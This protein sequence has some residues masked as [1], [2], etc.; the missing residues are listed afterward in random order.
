MIKEIFRYLLLAIVLLLLQL[1][2][3]N[4]INFHGFVNPYVYVMFVLVMPFSLKKWQLLVVG[5]VLGLVV[6]M[7]MNTLGLHAAATLMVAF[8]RPSI[9]FRFTTRV[10]ES[11]FDAPGIDAGLIWFLRYV[12]IA[13]LVHHSVLFFLE[14][15]TLRH[16]AI[17]LLRI[18]LSTAFTTVFILIIEAIRE[19][20]REVK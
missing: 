14:V 4:N 8:L 20:R 11:R 18:V 6:D 13:V 16:F 19:L 7:F 17:T 9:L 2:I 5:F 3:F 12:L 15:F 10:E 1:L